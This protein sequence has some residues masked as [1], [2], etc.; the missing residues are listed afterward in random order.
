MGALAEGL[1][2]QGGS[3]TGGGVTNPNQNPYTQEQMQNMQPNADGSQFGAMV[4][5]ANYGGAPMQTQ[6]AAQPT[7]MPS[8][9]FRM[10]E[11]YWNQM[12]QAAPTQRTGA[13]MQGLLEKQQGNIK[14]GKQKGFKDYEGNSL[15]FLPE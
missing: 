9:L 3:N 12:R 10:P 5:P 1:Q 8:G 2:G 15:L 4:A 14:A 7:Q 13:Q 6:Q 11:G